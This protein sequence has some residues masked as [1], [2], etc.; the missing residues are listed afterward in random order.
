M[1]K[2]LFV[3]QEYT[4]GGI[5]KC[6]ENLLALIDS[7]K[8]SISIFCLYEDGGDYYKKN[9]SPY[10]IKKS[11]FYYIVHDNV[12]TRK[13]MGLYNKIT[14][15]YNFGFLYKR[16][17]KIL[18]KKY[19]F[20]IVIAYHEGMTSEFAYYFGGVKKI[21]WLHCDPYYW[22]LNNLNKYKV[23]YNK[24]DTIVC[25]SEV[26]KESLNK[27]FYEYCGNLEIIH[28]PLNID[29][30]R[31][32]AKENVTDY[33][34]NNNNFR[35]ISIGRSSSIKQFDK[36]P[37]IMRKLLN[38]GLKDVEWYIIASGNECNQIIKNA[39]NEC[40]VDK[41][42]F[43]LGERNNPYPYIKKSD[44]LVSTSYSEAFPT[45]INEAQILGTPVVSNDYP[46]SKEIVGCKSGIIC[47][48]EQMPN[49]L[50]DIISNR[51]DKYLIIKEG[52][53]SFFYDN[54]A[55]LK[56]IDNLLS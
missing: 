55:I 12:V 48:L 34:N 35:I 24:I 53:M 19:C 26:V 5:N 13:L 8:Y 52:A 37:Y 7:S 2:I 28:N 16:E 18:Q 39:I 21:A 17:A 11:F 56:K 9:L 30:I 43:L 6:L 32:K 22:G 54:E 49:T 27:M 46:S 45:V 15:R 40:G 38:M 20:D 33:E 51:E 47:S 42:V 36:I 3:I 25:V 29:E 41:Y 10:L 44:L 50:F 31:C 23:F 1:K 14:N 4:Q